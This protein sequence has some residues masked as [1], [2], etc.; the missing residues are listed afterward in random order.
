MQ[1]NN[2]SY[3]NNPSPP[4]SIVKT[5]LRILLIVLVIIGIRFGCNW[6][7]VENRTLEEYLK[8]ELDY[9]KGIGVDP[10]MYSNEINQLRQSGINKD[11]FVSLCECS[12]NYAVNN[13]FLTLDMF[14][15]N[16]RLMNKVLSSSEKAEYE[17]TGFLTNE[18]DKKIREADV[19][20]DNE[21]QYAVEKGIDGCLYLIN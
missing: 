16:D 17:K 1:D 20:L 6:L 21:F 19:R 15:E 12:I 11:E 13:N 4:N 2:Y 18:M 9:C 10:V 8:L 14:K 7:T 3:D 5:F